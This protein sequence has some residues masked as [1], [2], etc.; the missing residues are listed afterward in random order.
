MAKIPTAAVAATGL[1][2]GYG[3]AR[4]SGRRELGGAVLAAAGATAAVQWGRQT[5]PG[6]AAALT[7]LYLAAFGASHPLA[8]RIGAWPAVFAVT[9]V[10]AGASVLATGS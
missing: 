9:A 10:V 3:T 4:W 5:G 1:I 6:A 2:G 7:G 8:K